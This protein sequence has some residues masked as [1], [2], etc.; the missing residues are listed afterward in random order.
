MPILI[1]QLNRK[2]AGI[3][4]CPV[5]RHVAQLR[6]VTAVSFDP[7]LATATQDC[8]RARF[9]G[10]YR[11]RIQFAEFADDILTELLRPFLGSERLNVKPSDLIGGRRLPG[12]RGSEHRAAEC[13]TDGQPEPVNAH[14]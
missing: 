10:S 9:V 2:K 8:V 5:G 1:S 14:G 13:K 11:Y 6:I 7:D 4:G 12:K 3:N